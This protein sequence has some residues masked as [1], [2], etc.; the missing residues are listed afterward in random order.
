MFERV[1]DEDFVLTEKAV[2]IFMRQICEGVDYMH[3]K[4]ILHLDM[5]VRKFFRFK[6]FILIM[7]LH[8]KF[9]LKYTAYSSL[10]RSKKGR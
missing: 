5:K 4:N 7:W 1:I 2:T 3:S 10:T 8:I 6:I 9:L